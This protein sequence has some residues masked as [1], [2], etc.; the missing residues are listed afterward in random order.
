[1]SNERISAADA[2]RLLDGAPATDAPDGP[3]TVHSLSG[4]HAEIHATH[5][6]RTLAMHV[7]LDVA[8]LL[9]AAPALAREVIALMEERDEAREEAATLRAEVER[10]RESLAE[11][12]EDR[13]RWREALRHCAH[14]SYVTHP[15]DADD[16]DGLA[17]NVCDVLD[18][19]ADTQA[20]VHGVA[21]AVWS[22][23][24]S[25]P[26]DAPDGSADDIIE[27]VEARVREIVEGRTVPPTDAEIAVH[28]ANGGRWRFVTG[29][30]SFDLL[31]ER[32]AESWREGS[33]EWVA[34][35]ARWWAL[36]S[37][38]SPCAWPV[39]GGAR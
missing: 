38:G 37:T 19:I 18:G 7:G 36:D 26:C 24:G 23:I 21:V 31:S 15:A 3:Y 34:G 9:A 12:T 11:V 39:V 17:E 1:M 29:R 33:S 13:E 16:P 27:A 22:A 35:S 25:D 30:E 10:L 2:R 5:A 6:D 20:A 14:E 8:P 28:A 4:V 32:A